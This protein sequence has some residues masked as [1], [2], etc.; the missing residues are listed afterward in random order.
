MHSKIKIE[1]YHKDE[2]FLL[3]IDG[4]EFLGKGE[5]YVERETGL[6]LALFH[7]ATLLSRITKLEKWAVLS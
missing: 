2:I 1:T 3:K 7:D 5:N 4:K 6:A